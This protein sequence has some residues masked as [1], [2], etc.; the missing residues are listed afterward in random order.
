MVKMGAT[1]TFLNRATSERLRSKP[2]EDCFDKKHRDSGL[3]NN[4]GKAVVMT[5]DDYIASEIERVVQNG[6]L[7][8]ALVGNLSVMIGKMEIG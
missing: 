5:Y 4:I 1:K 2:L 8:D 3:S 7:A 6:S